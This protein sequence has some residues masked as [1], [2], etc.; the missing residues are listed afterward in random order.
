MIN[1]VISIRA[2]QHY[3]YCPR[4]FALL[5][6]NQDWAENAFVAKGN[7]LHKHVHE[8]GHNYS[9]KNKIVRS[10][11]SLYNDEPELNIS[12]IADCV[13]FIKNANG[14]VVSEFD[15]LYDI[16]IIEYK[17]KPPKIGEYHDSDAI[18][19]FAQK[20]CADYIWQCNSKACIYYSETK[21]R[22]MLPFNE[23]KER[24]SKLLHSYLHDMRTILQEGKIPERRKGQKCSGCSLFDVCEP[25]KRVYNVK[26]EILRKNAEK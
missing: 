7:I 8:G 24:Y 19:V 21:R 20:M 18:Q 10:S 4:R 15:G 23:Q 17:P 13:E 3:M 6:I 12:G 2:I 25:T 9:D 1:E 26:K 22:V 5:E 16:L 14:I 11:V